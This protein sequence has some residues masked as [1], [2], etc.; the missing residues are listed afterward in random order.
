MRKV[1]V[2]CKYNQAR[3][4]TAAAAL[5]RFFPNEHI[6]SAGIIAKPNIPIPSSILQILDEWG[7]EERDHRST[8]TTD[9]P[10]I[11]PQDLVLCADE[12]VR[13]VFVQQLR[14]DRVSFP[15]TFILEEF[16][17]SQLEI[18]IDPVS[19]GEAE[20]KNQLARSIVLAIRGVN[21]ILKNNSLVEIGFLP[22]DGQEH[23]EIQSQFFERKSSNR[24]LI[25]VGFSIPDSN[26]WSPSMNLHFINP[27]KIESLEDPLVEK[28]VL[29]SKFE[30]DKTPEL[31]LSVKYFE[32]IRNL[33]S[34]FQ[35]GV[36]AQPFESL[37]QNRR[38]ES[39][40][41]M[42]HS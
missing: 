7:L 16:S 22:I 11:H 13:S 35:I 31:F 27:L 19:L 42:I 24:L 17:R 39:I 12:E 10:E 23:L 34:G 33:S 4:I 30:I 38:H 21:K 41:G 32:W 26:M 40:L 37:P 36:V 29:I 15:N 28:T 25:D 9:L 2:L 8:S 1:I 14:L 18:P 5:R 20:T 3:S 6:I